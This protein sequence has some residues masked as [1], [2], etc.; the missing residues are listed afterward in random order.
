VTDFLNSVLPTQGVYCTVGIRAGAVKQSFQQTIED[1]EAVGS[2]MDS[3]GVD[4]Y[5]ALATFNDDSG[6][7]VDNAAF[8][9]SFFLDLDCG[10][11]KPYADQAA[12]AQARSIF[13]SDTNLPSPT[14]VY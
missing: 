2:G 5:F 3:Q 8:L 9:R 4:A 7:K 1:V 13:N 10:T 11:G 6:R 14:D 12:A